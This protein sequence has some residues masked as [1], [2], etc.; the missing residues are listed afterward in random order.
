MAML[1]LAAVN[2]PV[3]ASPLAVSARLPA[4][5]EIVI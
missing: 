3:D 1:N 2:W 5:E 4:E